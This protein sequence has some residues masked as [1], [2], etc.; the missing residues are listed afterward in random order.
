MPYLLLFSLLI[1]AHA[2]E[3]F[4]QGLDVDLA[5]AFQN[6]VDQN[7]SVNL[8]APDMFDV[9]IADAT[10]EFDRTAFISPE[11]IKLAREQFFGSTHLPPD[12]DIFS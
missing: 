2:Q 4:T 12:T 1:M 6:L 5:A 3:D 9:V 10:E 8:T 11:E 7:A